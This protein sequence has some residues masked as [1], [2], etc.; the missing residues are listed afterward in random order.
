MYEQGR[1]AKYDSL[2][3]SEALSM[4][5]HESQSLLWERCVGQS[6]AFWTFFSPLLHKHLPGTKEASGKDFYLAVNRVTPS[7]I[8]VEAD[9]V[10]YPFHVIIRF[11]IE[12]GLMDGSIS[13]KDLPT[14]W[15]QKMKEYLGIDVP[16]DAKGVLQD[17]HWACGAIGYFPSYTMGAMIA[18]Q[19]YATA[20]SKIPNL[21]SEFTKGETGFCT[22]K[23]WLNENVHELGS[24][25]ASPDE[26]LKVVTGEALNP[27]YFLE[28]LTEKYRGIYGFD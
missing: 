24:L 13:V 4:G 11:E 26:L 14:I 27:K 23:K 7:L 2:P 9:E 16:S 25:Y 18:A 15:N 1:N 8:R 12:R 28:Y 22:L 21:E 20:K 5:V 17:V 3:V 6:E 19:I 10:T